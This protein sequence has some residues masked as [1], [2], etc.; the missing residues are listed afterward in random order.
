MVKVLWYKM[1]LSPSIRLKQHYQES[2]NDATYAYVN[3]RDL[4]KC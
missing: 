3:I 4:K 2:A 1:L